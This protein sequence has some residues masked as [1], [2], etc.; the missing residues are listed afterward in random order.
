MY[1][2]N[3]VAPICHLCWRHTRPSTLIRSHDHNTPQ[4][5]TPPRTCHLSST[6]LWVQVFLFR[7]LAISTPPASML[8]LCLSAH[9]QVPDTHTI[10]RT[11][12]L[13]CP[14]TLPQIN[15]HK[16]CRNNSRRVARCRRVMR[17]YIRLTSSA[18][19]LVWNYSSNGN[20]LINPSR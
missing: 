2:N 3:T 7:H 11:H 6:Y 9:R 20:S 15:T 1:A 14:H 10:T 19:V 5:R 17:V 4:P 12:P 16:L 18:Q 13:H 8:P